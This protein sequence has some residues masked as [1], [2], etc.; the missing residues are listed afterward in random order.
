MHLDMY[1]VLVATGAIIFVLG[2]L[3]LFYWSMD[4]HSLWLGWWAAPYFL[5][6]T[7]A[8]INLG[9]GSAPD[10]VVFGFGTAAILLA[11]GFVW[12][13]TR[14][15]ERR[16]PLLLPVFAVPTAWLLLCTWPYFMGNMPLRIAAAAVPSSTFLFL[17]AYEFWRGRAEHLL[18]RRPAITILTSFGLSLALHIPLIGVLPFPLGGLPVQPWAL[19]VSNII[20][21]AHAAFLAGLLI[22][23][24]RERQE[25]LQRDFAQSDPLTGLLNRRA[26]VAQAGR[27]IE[28]QR[29]INAPISLLML[30]LDHFKSVNDRFG[31]EVG[32]RV[33]VNFAKV[34]QEGVRPTDL[35][36]RIGGEE[37]CC[38]LPNAGPQDAAR[39][40]DRI[41]SRFQASTMDV[42][43]TKLRAT[44]SVGISTSELNGYDL[45]MLMAQ[46]DSAVYEAKAGG[47]NRSVLAGAPLD[48]RFSRDN[49][50]AQGRSA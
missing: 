19:A 48:G 11:L 32:D 6:A 21:F 2:A 43:G 26:F 45:N 17:S 10:F 37:F 33:L 14:V 8:G 38:L 39:I 47:R 50:F 20:T 25:A 3:F 18:S 27:I 22:S 30:D 28:R 7:A 5:G 44:V 29:F 35:T 12:Q 1:T 15:F 36:Y 23:M 24:T 34:L 40:A 49:R 41:C 16:R 31:H 13:G 42:L 46:A 4:R 9:R